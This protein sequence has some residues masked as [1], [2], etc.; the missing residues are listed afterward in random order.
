MFCEADADSLFAI[1]G[2]LGYDSSILN[3]TQATRSAVIKGV[4]AVAAEL[5]A[6][7][8]FFLS[9]SGHGG[10][11][12]DVNFDEADGADETWCLFDGQLIDDEL[13]VLWQTFDPLVR[14]LV[15]SDSCHSG[16][17]TRNQPQVT[18]PSG[19][20]A[21]KL[22]GTESPSFRYMPRVEA[23]RTYGQNAQFYDGIQRGLSTSQTGEGPMVLLISGC[24]DDQLSVEG[25]D[26]GLFTSAL[27]EVWNE[28]QFEGNYQSFYDQVLKSMPEIQQ[29]QLYATGNKEND[30]LHQSPFFI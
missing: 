20:L 24:R 10:Q 26:H 12:R 23:Q 28:G 22:Y 16:T 21:L 3:T 13:N 15:L 27:L 9:Y 4:R 5:T 30:F 6:G 17:V 7:D 25:W 1:A 19:E 29:P 2:G 18:M 14:I 8:I 11:V